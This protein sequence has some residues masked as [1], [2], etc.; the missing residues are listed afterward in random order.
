MQGRERPVGA[1][2]FSVSEGC[3]VLPHLAVFE[4]FARTL[5]F[6]RGPSTKPNVDI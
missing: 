2:P 1:L 3:I 5:A 6:R 4:G